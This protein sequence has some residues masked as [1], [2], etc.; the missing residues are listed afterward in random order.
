M[1]PRAQSEIS[2]WGIRPEEGGETG[3]E[4]RLLAASPGPS[5]TTAQIIEVIPRSFL[6]PRIPS[7]GPWIIR[8]H[9]RF[10]TFSRISGLFCPPA[11]GS[12]PV[13]LLKC[14]AWLLVGHV[15]PLSLL[16]GESTELREVEK[17]LKPG[18]QM[19]SPD[20]PRFQNSSPIPRSLKPW[21][22]RR[23]GLTQGHHKWEAAAGPWPWVSPQGPEQQPTSCLPFRPPS[24]SCS[25]GRKPVS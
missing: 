14:T 21:A 11:T 23:K 5:P 24:P 9:T 3:P 22:W 6:R 2:R 17:H 25:P 12:L 20:F 19:S 16:Q 8:D 13:L 18:K 10:F 15:N 1:P 7:P 4:P